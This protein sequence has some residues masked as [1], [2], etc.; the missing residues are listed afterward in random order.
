MHQ[1][2]KHQHIFLVDISKSMKII[3]D[4]SVFQLLFKNLCEA[5]NNHPYRNERIEISVI[6]F[7]E[8]LNIIVNKKTAK[9]IISIPNFTCNG[10]SNISNAVKDMKSFFETQRNESI[11][12]PTLTIFS[13]IIPDSL[14]EDQIIY[15]RDEFAVGIGI[16]DC[17]YDIKNP[18][19]NWRFGPIVITANNESIIEKYK[20]ISDK[21]FDYQN[22]NNFTKEYML[23]ANE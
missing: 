1:R 19:R 20:K 7:S 23:M 9:E 2:K 6:T 17:V 8:V 15:L 3:H 10:K 16:E 22:L 5:I 13:G 21:I 4:E 18:K 14:T 11:Y 12:K